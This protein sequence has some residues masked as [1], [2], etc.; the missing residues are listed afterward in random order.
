MYDL[1]EKLNGKIKTYKR[2]LE[3]AVS[4]FTLEILCDSCF[5]TKIPYKLQE[6]LATNNLTKYRQLQHQLEVRY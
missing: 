2:Q 4:Y 5:Q 6:E 3:E 1:M